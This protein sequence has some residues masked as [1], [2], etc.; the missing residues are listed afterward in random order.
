MQKIITLAFFLLFSVFS[1]AQ[2]I[3]MEGFITDSKTFGLEMANVMAVNQT[4]NAMDSYAI[5]NDKG[6]FQL[7]LKANT[8][9][10]IKVSYIGFQGKEIEVKTGT[11]NITQ[12]II[13]EEGIGLDE[14]EIVSE[15]PVSI[16]GDTIVYKKPFRN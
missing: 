9:Y 11:E 6:K 7:S 3:R 14:V 8:S 4:N 16:K 10:K 12:A 15:M 2:N 1:N 13:L 5:T